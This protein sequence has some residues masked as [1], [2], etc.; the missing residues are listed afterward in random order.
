MCDPDCLLVTE[1]QVVLGL[2]KH[3]L[4]LVMSLLALYQVLPET[5]KAVN[6]GWQANNQKSHETQ[7]DSPCL[8]VCKWT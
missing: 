5:A 3:V 8:Y 1:F 6:R 4:G 7:N 2:A